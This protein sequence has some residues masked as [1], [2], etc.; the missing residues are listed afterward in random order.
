MTLAHIT[1]ISQMQ[2]LITFEPWVC[3]YHSPGSHY[4]SGTLCRCSTWHLSTWPIPCKMF[5]RSKDPGT[6]AKHKPK[7]EFSF[8]KGMVLGTRCVLKSDRAFSPHSFFL[9]LLF[10][11]DIY[12]IQKREL[13]R[14][15]TV[16]QVLC[17]HLTCEMET[18]LANQ[19]ITY[20]H[21]VHI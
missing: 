2:N 7:K 13:T 20:L 19:L 6:T 14:V 5:T 3:F 10:W 12:P 4:C 16:S 21:D 8:K 1:L 15:N 11:V 18:F 17:T 9:L